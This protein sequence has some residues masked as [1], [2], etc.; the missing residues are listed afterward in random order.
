M[1]RKLYSRL[2]AILSLLLVLTMMP[3]YAFGATLS[4]DIY[5]DFHL[6]KNYDVK[7][8]VG[9]KAMYCCEECD[10]SSE[11]DA[12]NEGYPYL[13]SVKNSNTSVVK[14][15]PIDG[16]GSDMYFEMKG[17]KNGT[18]KV[19]VTF[20]TGDKSVFTVYVGKVDKKS[21]IKAKGY[22]FKNSKK[23][24]VSVTNV[25]KGDRIKLKIGNKTYTK[26]ITKAAAKKT[27]TIKI[28]KP[29]F[30][31]KKYKLSL[32]R[33]G[34][35]IASSKKYVYL[36]DTVY[37]GYTKKQVKW[38]IDWKDPDRI[39]QSAYSEQWCYDWGDER[40][41]LYFNNNGV[42]TNWQIFEY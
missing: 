11:E 34:K 16:D 15:Y 14:V 36:S 35:T 2:S 6:G 27:V 4:D 38:L 7:L 19:T 39:N 29:G 1:K 32:V 40:A 5:N 41:Y 3:V 8:K 30:Y 13:T 33:K 26:K 37:V 9:A 18:A 25:K 23:V 42:V 17:L 12:D 24:K 22:I 20:S 10:Y 21:I 28:S 31:G